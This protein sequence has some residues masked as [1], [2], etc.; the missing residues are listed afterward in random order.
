LVLAAAAL[1]LSFLPVSGAAQTGV[2]FVQDDKVGVGTA[3]PAVSFHVFEATGSDT[4]EFRLEN[5]GGN[6]FDF[7]NTRVPGGGHWQFINTSNPGGADLVIR[8]L[9]ANVSEEFRLTETGNLT[10]SGQI[11]T[12]GSTCGGGCDRV[13]EPGYELPSIEEHAALM[14]ANGFLP[15]V[16]PTK[17]GAPVNL[18]EKTGSML[19][20]LE[21]AHIYIEQLQNRV[22]A[23]ERQLLNKERVM[24]ERIARLEALLGE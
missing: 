21:K 15:A 18:S 19:N 20:E 22:T 14:R 23:L 24:S 3:A 17:E 16:G 11:F 7:V 8:E 10:I 13:F 4:T 5:N 9:T 6:R 1:A 12:G 2:L